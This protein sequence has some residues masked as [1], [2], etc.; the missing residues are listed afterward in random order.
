MLRGHE[1]SKLNAILMAA[2]FAFTI[3]AAFFAPD[4][5]QHEWI[6][7]PLFAAVIVYYF[8]DMAAA[9]RRQAKRVEDACLKEPRLRQKA[10]TSDADN[11]LKQ[12]VFE[13]VNVETGEKLEGITRSVLNELLEVHRAWGLESNDF[14]ILQ[15]SITVLE[16][17]GQS[18]LQLLNYLRHAVGNK[19]DIT[20]RWFND[21]DT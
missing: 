16:E 3:Y 8:I 20:I 12:Q 9:S 13:A 11:L 17:E 21:T 7:L 10:A 14:F 5:F 18:T 15:E 6:I 4:D 2:L 1:I 19:T